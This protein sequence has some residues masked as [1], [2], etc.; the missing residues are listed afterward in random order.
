[1]SKTVLITGCT[2]GIGKE[3]ALLFA[4]KGYTVFATS[5]DEGKINEVEKIER[6]S[7]SKELENV[8]WLKMD[9]TKKNEVET[10]IQRVIEKSGK[11][12][13]L[14]NNAGVGFLGEFENA[15]IEEVK[16]V[17]EVNVFGVMNV[18]QAILPHFRERKNGVIVNVSSISGKIGFPF[19][20]IYNSSKFALEGFIEGLQYELEPFGIRLKLIEPGPVKTKFFKDSFQVESKNKEGANK[21]PYQKAKNKFLGKTSGQN[22]STTPE[23]VANLIYKASLDE[24]SRIRYV[25]GKLANFLSFFRKILPETWFFFTFKNQKILD[26]GTNFFRSKK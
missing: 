4:K 6:E 16:R 12:D 8:H 11:I 2:S 5:K 13:I 23:Q 15:N 25:I 18:I 3:T 26:M 9:V 19:Y 14:I 20:S 24:S 10:T 21:N 1:M 17:F 7:Y 22:S